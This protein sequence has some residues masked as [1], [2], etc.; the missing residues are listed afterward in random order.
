MV[1]CPYCEEVLEIDEI[2]VEKAR[3]GFRVFSC[4]KCKKI[5]SCDFTPA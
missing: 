2:I 1:F 5:L 4:P 3:L